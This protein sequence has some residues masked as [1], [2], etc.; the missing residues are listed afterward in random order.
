[1]NWLASDAR[2]FNRSCAPPGTTARS[3]ARDQAQ[4]RGYHVVSSPQVREGLRAHGLGR[5][6]CYRARR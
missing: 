6:W 5:L 1:M 3:K 4:V 2:R